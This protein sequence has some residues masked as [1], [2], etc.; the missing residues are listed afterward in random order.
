VAERA[1]LIAKVAEL[2]LERQDALA[3]IITREMGKPTGDAIGEIQFSAAIYQY[4]ADNAE[5]FLADEPIELMGGE[6]SAIVRKSPLGVLL[7][8]MPWNFPY[9]QVAVSPART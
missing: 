6:G 8:I 1:A 9:Y 5:Q 2:H 3:A 7:G 4:Y